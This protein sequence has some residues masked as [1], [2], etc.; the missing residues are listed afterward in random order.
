MVNAGMEEEEQLYI[1]PEERLKKELDPS[2]VFELLSIIPAGTQVTLCVLE[3]LRDLIEQRIQELASYQED[4]RARGI[5][6]YHREYMLLRD[7]SHDLTE[8]CYKADKLITEREQNKENV[9]EAVVLSEVEDDAK[10]VPT[11]K[12]SSKASKTVTKDIPEELLVT[13]PETNS[14]R[15]KKDHKKTKRRTAEVILKAKSADVE[16]DSFQGFDA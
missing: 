16:P 9:L 14:V 12:K 2:Q 4:A 5:R 1:S 10:V 6:M 8:A 7:M 11:P 13:Q 15:E 3:E